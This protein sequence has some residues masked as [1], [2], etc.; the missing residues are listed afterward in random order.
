MKRAIIAIYEGVLMISF[1]IGILG[2][3][4][5]CSD[6][7]MLIW[8]DEYKIVG[9]LIGSALGFIVMSYVMGVGFLL[10]GIYSELKAFRK[11]IDVTTFI[12]E[13]VLGEIRK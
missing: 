8:G 10:L 3:T 1:G 2:S 9:W 11:Q 13:Q 6:G 12:I 4:V 5:L 7:A